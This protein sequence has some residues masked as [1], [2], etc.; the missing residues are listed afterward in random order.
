MIK[1]NIYLEEGRVYKAYNGDL[2]KIKK[3]NKEADLIHLFNI[4]EATSQWIP[5]KYAKIKIVCLIR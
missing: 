2:L 3:I 5:L 1:E 4:S